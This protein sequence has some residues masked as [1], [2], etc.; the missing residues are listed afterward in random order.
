MPYTQRHWG[1]QDH[2]PA[3]SL[4]DNAFRLLPHLTDNK[5]MNRAALYQASPETLAAIA[6]MTVDEVNEAVTELVD[7]EIILYDE[8]TRC[9]FV[10]DHIADNFFKEEGQLKRDST[11]LGLIKDLRRCSDMS[12]YP[13]V[14]EVYPELVELV[15]KP[16]VPR[17][18]RLNGK[19]GQSGKL[20]FDPKPPPEPQVTEAEQKYLALRDRVKPALVSIYDGCAAIMQEHSR[21]PRKANDF[22]GMADD[23]R[24][25]RK[26]A[27]N[28]K[29]IIEHVLPAL[30]AIYVERREY[31]QYFTSGNGRI[32]TLRGLAA[33]W[34]DGTMKAVGLVNR[35]LAGCD[36]C[37]V[38]DAER[39]E[40]LR[41]LKI[42]YRELKQAP[43]VTE[44]ELADARARIAELEG[45][46][47]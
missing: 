43:G 1:W 31:M 27:E 35:Y 47:G 39:A 3:V 4:S 24:A 25:I 11:G 34:S 30:K 32:D 16:E 18:A 19:N 28:T 15:P 21:Q 8:D 42:E 10:I 13:R 33:K 6:R 17:R 2:E 45:G 46:G 12:L 44:D 5:L 41:R 26:V 37:Q 29:G 9:V 7:R 14:L 20:Q 23:L 22:N 36:Q 38:S 40:E